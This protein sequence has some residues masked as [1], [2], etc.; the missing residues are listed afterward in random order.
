MIQLFRLYMTDGVDSVLIPNMSSFTYRATAEST[1][2]SAVIEGMDYASTIAAYTKIRIDQ[3]VDG[4]AAEMFTA[5]VTGLSEYHSPGSDTYSIA[6]ED[7]VFA[8]TAADMVV[9]SKVSYAA[10]QNYWSFRINE[11]TPSLQPGIGATYDGVEFYIGEVTAFW[12]ADGFGYT[13]LTETDE[14]ADE[15]SEVIEE[16][17]PVCTYALAF[18]EIKWVQWTIE[19]SSG[20]GTSGTKT[21]PEGYTYDLLLF[22]CAQFEVLADGQIQ[23]EFTSGRTGLVTSGIASGTE[24]DLIRGTYT[25]FSDPSPTVKTFRGDG[26]F[27]GTLTAGIYTCRATLYVNR[28]VDLNWTNWIITP[29][30]VFVRE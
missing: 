15:D 11:L 9:D 30:N 22:K 21:S 13:T 26:F 7:L 8:A 20:Y 23:V 2:G 24:F 16:G 25:P 5:D 29:F 18:D 3:V 4:V 6:F 12:S 19:C 28:A 10:L 1:T 27:I 14:P 17:L